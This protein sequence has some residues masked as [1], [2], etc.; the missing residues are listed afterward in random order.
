MEKLE[1]TAASQR[2]HSLDL[3]RGFAILGILIMNIISFSHFGTGYLNPT[4]GAG[5]EGYNAWFHG[6]SHLFAD[7]RFMS[8]FSMLFG[9]GIVLFSE[10]AERKG[11]KVAKYHYRRMFFLMVFG[12]IHAYLIWM[13]DI[14]I[15]YAI[16]GS[17]VFL[18]RKA[19]T[20]T[21]IILASIFFVIPILFSL[22]TY[23]ATPKSMLEEIFSFWNPSAEAIANETNA[24]LGS[25]LDQMEPR[26]EGATMM[27]TS[28]FLFEAIWRISTMMIL[29][30]ILYRKGVLNA[31]FPA[32]WYQRLF[33]FA[34]S[35]GLFIS[36]VGLYRSYEKNWEGI[37]YMNIGHHYN[38]VASLFMALGY[39]GL[40][41][42][43]SKS[44]GVLSG[45]KSRVEAAGR[46]AFTN[47]I[48]T[49]I[50]CITIFYG[51]G[52]GL[53]GKLDRLQQW[54]IIL[55]VW[56]LILYLSPLILSKYKQG[57]LEWLWR[58]FTYLR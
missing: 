34:F 27:L 20:R 35:I 4:L 28:Y 43:W 46:M 16:C 51:H 10:N 55:F 6:F 58:K 26:V 45:L 30:M 23:Y 22:M 12:V 2:I 37:W 56:I 33:L 14:L 29:G 1:A 9:A 11:I 3:L 52:L 41:M 57:P 8:L 42:L 7:M 32:G 50:I 39:I 44:E 13:G 21:L 54:G 47:Y 49:S 53:F 18:L 25:Y 40:I 31:S 17:L 48:G 36:A 19:K 15:Q 38:Y 5:I 24:Y